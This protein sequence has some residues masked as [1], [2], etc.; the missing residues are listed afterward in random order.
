MKFNKTNNNSNSDGD[1]NENDSGDDNFGKLLS[2][3]S[4]TVVVHYFKL[5]DFYLAS[6]VLVKCLR[7]CIE[8]QTVFI[9][10]SNSMQNLKQNVI[11]KLD[12]QMLYEILYRI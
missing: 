1:N 11:K 4:Q 6:F 10:V 9:L 2:N 7:F 3:Y 8:S 5:R 12:K